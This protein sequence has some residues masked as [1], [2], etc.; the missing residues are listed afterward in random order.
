MNLRSNNSPIDWQ[1]LD[2]LVDGRLNDDE[3]RQLLCQIDANPNGWKQCALAFLEHQALEKELGAFASDPSSQLLPCMGTIVAESAIKTEDKVRPSS[4]RSPVSGALIGWMSMALCI[5]G[6]LA[7]GFTLSSDFQD[8]LAP[9]IS[10]TPA[11]V[12]NSTA[13]VS[14]SMATH[15]GR[16]LGIAQDNVV[17]PDD[18]ATRKRCSEGK[19][20]C[21]STRKWSYQN[22][23]RNI[24]EYDSAS[25]SN[26]CPVIGS[27]DEPDSGCGEDPA[28]D[29]DGDKD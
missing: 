24:E 2:R 5:F 18:E 4:G 23:K 20:G 9:Q 8:N 16:G 22:L 10:S 29:C 13:G 17:T 25:C 28:S 7:L 15:S 6:G 1:E 27:L 19:S 21:C 3:Y 26:V 11:V 12:D 14:N